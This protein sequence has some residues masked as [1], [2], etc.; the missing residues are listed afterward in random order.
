MWS[1][2]SL[3]E[4]ESKTEVVVED[5]DCG[6]NVRL[7]CSP[8]FD[9]QESRLFI[10]NGATLKMQQ[11]CGITVTGQSSVSTG[12]NSRYSTEFD[13]SHNTLAALLLARGVY[14]DDR[15]ARL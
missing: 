12:E 4:P 3:A 14:H 6:H 13:T 15:V 2:E 7:Q 9:S 10:V 11:F 5:Q 1:G 8:G